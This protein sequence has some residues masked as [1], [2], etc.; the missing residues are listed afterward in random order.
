MRTLHL[1]RT[2]WP[3]RRSA[4]SLCGAPPWWQRGWP[5]HRIGSM[6]EAELLAPLAELLMPQVPI[7]ELFRSFP[8]PK[9]WGGHYL[10]PDLA[11][12][13]V[14]KD[15]NAALFVE[16][17]GYWRHGEKE[18][19]ERDRMKN[20][21][22]L[23]YAPEGS[24]V[25]RISHTISK[26]MRGNVLWVRAEPWRS[27]HPVLV[28][29]IYGDIIEQTMNRLKHSLHPEVMERLQQQNQNC[30][31]VLSTKVMGFIREAKTEKGGNSVE[32]ISQFLVSSG[33]SA[34]EVDMMLIKGLVPGMLIEQK[35][36]PTLQLFLDLGLTKRQVAKAVATYPRILGHNVEQNLK[37]TV[38]WFSDI[39]L[40]KTQVAK[41]VARQPQILG[42]SIEQNLKPTVQLLSDMGLANTQVVK[43]VATYPRILGL[44][45]QQNLKPTVQWFSDLGLAK[46]QVAK[47]V[48]NHPQ[49]L[50]LN[51][52]QNLKPTVQWMSDLG[53][54]RSQIVKTLAT[55]PRILG[56][57][58]EQNLKPTVEWFLD[59]GLSESEVARAV[60]RHP[61]VLWCSVDQNLKPT[62][63]WFLD[64]GMTK[65]QVASAVATNPQLLGFSIVKNLNPKMLVL[66]DYFT[67]QGAAELVAKWPPLLG[68]SYQ[69]LTTRLKI[70]AE[71]D[72]I[73]KLISGMSL[74]EEYFQRRFLTGAKEWCRLSPFWFVQKSCKANS[75]FTQ[76][77]LGFHGLSSDLPDHARPF[78]NTQRCFHAHPKQRL[79]CVVTV[80]INASPTPNL[81]SQPGCRL[82]RPELGI[83]ATFGRDG[84][85]FGFQ[86]PAVV[87]CSLD[88]QMLVDIGT[89]W[90]HILTTLVVLGMSCVMVYLD[91]LWFIFWF[92]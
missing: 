10:E 18:G 88:F 13:G 56:Y 41:A 82:V 65:S 4:G 22:L 47:A 45:I 50:G 79:F 66:N 20:A 59:L 40:A 16:Y 84:C 90:I 87:F 17:D 85:R 14:L 11:A 12:Y 58:I 52:E 33:F 76:L 36:R 77:E 15:A 89:P 80:P 73:N 67:A 44:S 63:Q 61:S 78:S 37:P 60:A 26:P 91:L 30:E 68:Y 92:W 19:M 25:V 83:S 75:V 51:I 72:K 71:Q 64:L 2:P 53:L 81:T 57:S 70:L 5:R 3:S 34:I 7:A 29:K 42:L 62:V 39:G 23:K 24:Y 49:I 43:A 86:H 27:G 9:G 48:A 35:L 38:Q 74:K 1:F 31:K 8:S 54:T 69:R 28:S 6:A 32:E 21:A 55:H 46:S